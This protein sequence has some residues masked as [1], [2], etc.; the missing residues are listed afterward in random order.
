VADLISHRDWLKQ[1]D[2][3]ITSIRSSELKAIDAALKTYETAPTAANKD[4]VMKALVRWFQKEGPNWKNSVRNKRNA[5]DTLHRQLLG[6]GPEKSGEGMIA[7]SHARDESR[8]IVHD[9]FQGQKLVYRSGFWNKLAGH[10]TFGKIGAKITVSG[11]AMNANTLSGGAI[12]NG[13]RSAPGAMRGAMGSSMGGSMNVQVVS[14]HLVEPLLKEL[15]PPDIFRDVMASLVEVLPSFMTEWAAACAPFAALITSG[16]GVVA[17]AALSLRAEWRVREGTIHGQRTL[18][19]DE[20]DKA[21]QAI[22]LMLDRERTYAVTGLGVGIA[23]FGGKLAGVLADGGTATTA[24]IGLAQGVAKLAMLISAIV[25]DVREKNAAN[26]IMLGTRVG[27]ELFSACPLMGAYLVCCAPTS[28][29]VNT[30][31]DSDKFFQPGMMDVVERAVKRHVQP[32]RD[33]ARRLATEHRMYIPALSHFPGML[34]RSK[35]KL[36]EMMK[37]KGKTDIGLEFFEGSA[38]G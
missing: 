6:V 11:V 4:A 8:A 22:V 17:S 18:S 5:V 25:I 28:V 2:G 7:L 19:V 31:F 13:V 38:V 33:A 15:I 34:E 37:N 27:P 3:G 21:M 16:G 20:P 30:I 36:K 1:T 26:K 10:G 14:P 9:L 32:M 35:K 23:A 24:A 12:V 29:L